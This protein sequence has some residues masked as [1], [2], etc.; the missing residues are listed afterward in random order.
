MFPTVIWF[1]ISLLIH[2]PPQSVNTPG[3]LV[4]ALLLQFSCFSTF[5]IILLLFIKYRSFIYYLFKLINSEEIEKIQVFVNYQ[6]NQ[7]VYV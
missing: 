1:L 5:F 3:Y 6:I 2:R 4:I 7:V